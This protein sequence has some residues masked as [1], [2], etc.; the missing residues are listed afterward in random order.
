[1]I[2]AGRQPHPFRRLCEQRPARLVGRR[3]RVEQWAIGFRIGPDRLVGITGRLGVA[4]GGDA[5]GDL[6]RALC[7][8]RQGQVGGAYRLNL[9]M[10][11]DA[12]EQR[13]GHPRLIIGGAAWRPCAGERGIAE[14]PLASLDGVS[15][16]EVESAVLTFNIDDFVA[17]FGPGTTFTQAPETIVLF[18]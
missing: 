12:V 5:G 13:P 17:T 7:R 3:Y 15:S 18:S 10:E 14:M 11:V 8:W 1:M 4:G 16:G 2:A 6:G 9:D